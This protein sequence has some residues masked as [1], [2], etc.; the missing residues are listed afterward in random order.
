METISLKNVSFF[1]LFGL[2]F[3][4][5][6]HNSSDPGHAFDLYVLVVLPGLG[7]RRYSIK[8]ESA[9]PSKETINVG[10]QMKFYRQSSGSTKKG[11]NRLM[12][13]SNDCYTMWIDLNTNM[14][15]SITDR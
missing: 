12:P 11:K 4:F 13:L 2:I 10:R 1:I 15:A 6:I 3:Q 9:E 8:S 7:Y 5:Q 14:L